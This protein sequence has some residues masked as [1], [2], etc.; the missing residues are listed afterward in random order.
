MDMIT[1]RL[2]IQKS[3]AGAAVLFVS[4]PNLLGREEEVWFAHISDTHNGNPEAAE[5]LKFVL[6]D[7][8]R[9]YPDAE[10]VATTGDITEHGWEE[11]LEENFEIMEESDLRYYNVMGNHDSRWSRSGRKAFRDTFGGAHWAVHT[12]Y[13]SV[14]LIDSSVLLEQYGFL[15]PFELAWLEGQLKEINGKPAIIGFHHPP[16]DPAQYIGSERELFNIISRHNIPV[17]L[18]GHI[19][20]L[21]EYTVNGTHIITGG[22]T[23]PPQRG[24]NIFR[25]GRNGIIYFTRN[26]I[27]DT[28]EERRKIPYDKRDRDVPTSDDILLPEAIH[29]DNGIRIP[30]PQLRNQDEFNLRLN[31]V[32]SEPNIVNGSITLNQSLR[33]GEYEVMLAVPSETEARQRRMWGTI[34]VP[35]TTGRVKWIRKLP[36][37][38]QCRPAIAGDIIVTG[39]NNGYLFGLARESGH[40]V[41]EQKISGNELLSSPV[42]HNGSI[43]IGSVDEKIL[44][45]DPTTGRTIWESPVDGSVIA[46]IMMTPDTLVVG[47]G[48]GKLYALNPDDGKI[49]WV[50]QTG[51]LIKATPAYEDGRLLF[52]SWDGY[53]YCLDASNGEQIW[54]KYINIPHFAP[55]TSNPMVHDGR[56]YFVSHDYRTHCL[57]A[58]TG[59]VVWQF[60]AA[61]VEYNYRSPI[62]DRCKPSYS[63]AVFRKDNVYFCSLTGHVVG[64]DKHTGEQTF[65]FEL[66][67]PVF[68]SFPVLVNDTMYF[69]TIRGA[70]CALNL[71]SETMEWSHN[72]GY[73]YIFS[74]P[75]VD[76][77]ELV[78]GSLGGSIGLFRI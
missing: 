64:F 39:C 61:E 11:E 15:D 1:R 66:D 42:L 45:L 35:D 59:S 58:E 62:I 32:L 54:K 26:P 10:F 37:G 78:I 36:A 65:E 21:K 71:A 16:C 29:T 68:D 9:Q 52:G 13:C 50:F 31:G 48:K 51:N 28:T 53:F 23:R 57:N 63:S 47:T 18:A 55:A 7:I 19:H 14:F 69:G 40:T 41:W 76:D 46:T 44:A 67:A 75:E 33:A 3:V 2:F 38:I 77:N 17:I 30:I 12:G 20:S 5:N 73:E 6:D 8:R 60:P 27:E 34:T 43:Y 24:Y 74:P 49:I 56:V 22:S 70:V 72:F 4:G 25:L